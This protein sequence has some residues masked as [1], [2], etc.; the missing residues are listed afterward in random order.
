MR[1]T[2]IFTVIVI[3]MTYS[4]IFAFEEWADVSNSGSI[5]QADELTALRRE[6]EYL[7]SLLQNCRLPEEQVRCT[8]S[9]E[10]VED[11]TFPDGTVTAPG[12]AFRKIWRLR[13]T[14]T[15]IWNRSYKVVSA[16][17]FH[18]GGPQ[19]AYL[20]DTVFPGETADIVMDLVSP[21]IYGD[22]RS[23]YLLEDG[24]GNRF[25]I[26]GTRT[27]KEMPFWLEL[28]VADTS[29]CSLISVS[30]Y[31]VWRYSDFDAVFRVKNNS[32]DLWDADEIDVRVSSG[33]FFLK[34][35]DKA[36]MDLP[37]SVKPGE[38]AS[39]IF[40]MIAPDKAGTYRITIDLEKNGGVICSADNMITVL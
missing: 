33:D 7:R 1:K 32:D 36:L 9:A 26:T 40:D 13:N 17:E 21:V 37:G 35:K 16:G 27:G 11:L 24:L 25:G 3:I 8:N 39:V 29:E 30:P 12:E 28:A 10:F 23:E 5:P 2:I 4:N 31:T 20:K 6:N 19:Y 38:A 15:C 14:G 22:F 18:M 34:Y